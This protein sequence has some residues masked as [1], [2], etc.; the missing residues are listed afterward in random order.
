MSPVKRDATKQAKA[1]QRRHLKAHE[2]IA[3]DRCQAQRAAEALQQAL[4]ALGLPEDLVAEI[5]RRLRIQHK[6]L[7]K[8]V[9]VM[10][11]TLFG[12]RTNTELCRIRGWDKNL[13]SRVLGALPKRSWIKRL[14]RLGLE[15]LVP[16]W[17]YAASKS[18]ATRSR[19]QWTWVGDDSVFKKYG[20]QLSLVGTWWSGQEHRVLSGIDGVL[21]V[22]VIGD[23][24]LVVPVDFAIRRPDPAGPGGPC[25]DKLHWV[26]VM[27]DGRLG[28]LHK[29]DVALP[30]PILVADSWLGD[31]KLMTMWRRRTRHLAG[32]GQ[33]ILSFHLGRWATDQRPRLDQGQWVAL[34]SGSVEGRGTVRAASRHQ[35][36]L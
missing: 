29:R 20:D 31:S 1:R 14:R 8:I 3:R 23:G 19:W 10:F 30:P 28:A 17:R 34:A 18:E 25:R 16:L 27:L 12:C 11:P 7:G 26:Q 32:R 24:K 2:R 9:G 15:V 13:P 36:D 6:L 33:S 21:L 5:E 22:V 35:S 4:D